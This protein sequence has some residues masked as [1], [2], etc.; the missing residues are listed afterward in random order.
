M[1][2]DWERGVSGEGLSNPK[3]WKEGGRAQLPS[4][5]VAPGCV[6]ILNHLCIHLSIHTLSQLCLHHL[7]AAD[8]ES[9]P[10][11]TSQPG[12]RIQPGTH[13]QGA[14][15]QKLPGVSRHAGR[16]AGGAAPERRAERGQGRTLHPPAKGAW[17]PTGREEGDREERP[18]QT[19]RSRAAGLEGEKPRGKS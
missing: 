11:R 13:S 16:G 14:P 5:G 9:S 19:N 6:S 4:P 8:R 18:K 2:T 7:L 15:A 17:R 3:T 10:S 12:A 1:S